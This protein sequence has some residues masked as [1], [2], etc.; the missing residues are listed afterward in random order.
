MMCNATSVAVLVCQDVSADNAGGCHP[1]GRILQQDLIEQL[2]GLATGSE[3][4]A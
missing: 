2:A 1:V 3:S 4:N